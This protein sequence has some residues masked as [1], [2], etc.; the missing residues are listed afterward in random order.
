M[1]QI[2]NYI[3]NNSSG[4]IQ[5][6]IFAFVGVLLGLIFTPKNNNPDITNGTSVTQI[7]QIIQQNIY[8]SPRNQPSPQLQP[9]RKS[10][11]KNSTDDEPPLAFY[12]VVAVFLAFFFYKYHSVLMDYTIGFIIMGLTSTITVAIK[13]HMD[14]QYDNLNKYWSLVALVIIGMDF[15]TLRLMSNQISESTSISSLS[16]FIQ[17]FGMN[18]ILQ[19]SYFALGFIVIQ[20]LNLLLL[21]LLIHMF[22]V[23]QY[24]AR[25]GRISEFFVRKTKGF[26][27][28][29]VSLAVIT[30]LISA[31]SIL[32]SSG[33]LYDWVSQGINHSTALM[34]NFTKSLSESK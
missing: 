22:A 14:N 27:S 12:L 23:N 9:Q 32:L 7:Q 30:V 11:S 15:I 33:I 17:A 21:A 1:S 8:Y 31:V 16:E 6:T 3:L 24:L 19:V 28:K 29:P 10:K 5:D 18:G 4:I 25:S 13:L 34:E 26:V 20:L 2:T